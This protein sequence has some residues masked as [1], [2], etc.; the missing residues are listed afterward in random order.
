MINK[1]YVQIAMNEIETN[2]AID[3]LIDASTPDESQR[4]LIKD[5]IA[6][7]L[8]TSHFDTELARHWTRP[9]PYNSVNNNSPTLQMPFYSV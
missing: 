9:K 7:A 8:R 1:D 3:Q 6:A 5:N 4:L 2:Q